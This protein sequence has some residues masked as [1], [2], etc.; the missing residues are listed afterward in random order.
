M[1]KK[2]SRHM[3]KKIMEYFRLGCVTILV[4]FKSFCHGLKVGRVEEESN[5][6]FLI[7]PQS[8]KWAYDNVN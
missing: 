5:M 4:T 1:L 3:V 2:L 6:I 8:Y 7:Q